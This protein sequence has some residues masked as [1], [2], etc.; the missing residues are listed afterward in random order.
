[1]ETEPVAGRREGWRPSHNFPP[2]TPAQVGGILV[3]IV[4]TLLL[5]FLAADSPSAGRILVA[6]A[7]AL[8]N[9][10]HVVGLFLFQSV[11]YEGVWSRFFARLSLIGTPVAV[12]ASILIG[13][14][15]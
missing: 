14:L 9:L 10:A 4:G 11:G 8:V 12:V 7:M 13:V 6:L 3:A 2:L 15:D 5:G 1:E